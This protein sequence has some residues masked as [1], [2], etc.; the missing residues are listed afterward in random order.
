MSSVRDLRRALDPVILAEDSGIEP[1]PWQKRALRSTSL[2]ILFNC[3]RQSGKSTTAGVLAAHKALYIPRSLV[4]LLSP[5]LRQ[6]QELFAKTKAVLPVKPESAT[7]LTLELVNGS[8]V[9]SLPGT[10]K[11]IRGYSG[12]ALLIVDEAARISDELY[13]AVRPMLAVSGGQLTMMSTPHGKRGAFFEAWQDGGPQWERYEISASECPRISP[14]FLEEER[15]AMP[16]FVFRQEYENSFE[17]TEDQVFS[18]DLVTAAVTPE[19]EPLSF[20]EDTW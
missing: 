15:K 6:S 8:R 17:E 3:C 1:D 19:V 13:H 10:E 7:A 9:V 2:R 5:T 4:L 11:T 12:A 16:G 20:G 14:E 18:H